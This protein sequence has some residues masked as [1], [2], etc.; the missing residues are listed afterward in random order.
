[1]ASGAVSQTGT[2]ETSETSW[3]RPRRLYLEAAVKVRSSRCLPRCFNPCGHASM[4]LQRTQFRMRRFSP[5]R[6][7]RPRKPHI[8]PQ[9]QALHKQRSIRCR[10]IAMGIQHNLGTTVRLSI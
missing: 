1:M 9:R 7:P 5:G 3:S 4:P 8:K 6:Q 10:I 2:K